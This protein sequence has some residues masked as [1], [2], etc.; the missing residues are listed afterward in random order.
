MK[1]KFY[2]L[3]LA[4]AATIS[5]KDKAKTVDTT[6]ATEQT[7]EKETVIAAN[8]LTEQEKQDGWTLLFNGTSLEGWHSYN[9]KDSIPIWT[10]KDGMLVCDPLS[11]KGNH[12]DLLTDK[13]YKNYE[14]KFE[15]KL[16]EGGNSGVFINVKEDAN[17]P[18]AWATGPEYQLLDEKHK[19]IEIEEKKSGCL[20]NFS[21]QMTETPNKEAGEWNSAIIKQNNGKIEFYLNGNITAKADFS[22]AEWKDFVENSGFKKFPEFGRA[23]E[24][25]IALQE[26]TSPVWF[27][28]IKIREL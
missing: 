24:G 3:L 9:K 5:C 2:A 20:Y 19:D 6:V 26:W 28:N 14:L 1:L 18:F 27:R 21:K 11:G 12:G 7:E 15:W 25:H 17:I 10:V 16:S 23:T 8:S 22:G 13:Q 4:A